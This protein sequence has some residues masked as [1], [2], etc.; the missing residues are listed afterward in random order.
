M[1]SQGVIPDFDTH[2]LLIACLC[3]NGRSKEAAEIVHEMIETGR[4]CRDNCTDEAVALFQKLGALDLEFSITI[5]TTMVGA[6]YKAQ[7][8]EQAKELF[9]AVSSNGL[10]PNASTYGV[11]ITNLLKEGSLEE[12]DHMF[13]S[14]EKSG[15]APSSVLINDIIRMLLEKGEIVKAGNYLSK[16]DGKSISLDTSTS[17][18]MMSLFSLEGKYRDQVKLLPARYQFYGGVSHS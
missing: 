8:T 1:T 15:C 7:R 5:F 16:V 11:M 14:M 18:L 12:A 4:L 9:A 2:K 13:S 3:K 17:L 6:M 10:I